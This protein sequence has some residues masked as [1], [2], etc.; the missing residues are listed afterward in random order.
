MSCLCLGLCKAELSLTSSLS[1]A[2]SSPSSLSRA[3]SSPSSL[4]R[5]LSLELSLFRGLCKAALSSSNPLQAQALSSSNPLKLRISL[6]RY[7][8]Q[9]RTLQLSLF[10]DASP[11]LSLVSIVHLK[12]NC[13]FLRFVLWVSLMGLYKI[14]C[15]L[16]IDSTRFLS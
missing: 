2:L 8:S 9:A 14:F 13:L 11:A 7:S 5:S 15:V 6:V 12:L 1:R 16:V 4:S 3:L 10:Y